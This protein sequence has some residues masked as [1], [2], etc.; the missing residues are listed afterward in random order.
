[1]RRIAIYLSGSIKKGKEDFSD[2]I[3]W[4][5]NEVEFI[6]NN[7][8]GCIVEVINPAT[9]NIS[10]VNPLENFGGDLYLVKRSDFLIADLREKRGIGVGSEMTVAKYYRIPIISICPC[11][12]YYRRSKLE[13]VCGE[14]LY[15][16]T[17]PFVLGL[18]DQIVDTLEQAVS[19]INEYLE[20]PF[21]IKDLEEISK[22]LRKPN[23]KLQITLNQWVQLKSANIKTFNI[24][25]DCM[26]LY[27]N[28]QLKNEFR[29]DKNADQKE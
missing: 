12:T 18:S 14:D 26:K 16:W 15:D 20:H 5:D 29:G 11:E 19:W 9:A 8:Y 22:P 23:D 4:N 27:I 1:M 25:E 21:Y 6:K 3:Y 2:S 13:N 7:L 28:K 24:I 17:H 10:R